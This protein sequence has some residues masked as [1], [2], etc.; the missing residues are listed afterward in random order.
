MH[1]DLAPA[2]RRG[3]D[4]RAALRD[5]ARIEGGLRSFLDAAG[6]QA[7]TDTFEDLDGLAQLPGIAAQRL[8]ADGYGFAAEGD[9]KTAA[10]V[11]IA[12]VM[13]SGLDGGTSFME[14]YTYDLA[15]EGQTRARG[16]HARGLPVDRGTAAVVR[17]PPALDRRQGRSG[18]PRLHGGAGAGGARGDCS[19]SAIASGSSSTRSSSCSPRRSCRACRWPARC[20]VPSRTSPTAAEAW[21]RAGGP[22]HTVLCRAIGAEAFVDLAEI[23]GIE[24]LVID[25]R[26]RIRDFANELRWNQAYYRLARGHVVRHAALRERVLEANLALGRAGLV[27]LTFGNASAID[28]DAGIVAIKPSGVSLDSLT[29]TDIAVVDLASGAVVEGELRPSSDTPTHLA[30]YRAWRDVGGIVHTHSP[31]ATAWAQARLDIPCYGTTHADH[32]DGAVPVTRPLSSGEIEGEYERATGDV[33]V[34]TLRDSRARPA[35]TAGGARCL[36]RPLH[37]GSDRGGGG[38]ER[39]RPRGSRGRRVPLGRPGRKARAD[40]AGAPSETLLAQAR[41]SGLLRPADVKALRLH[42]AGDLRLHEEPDPEPH[43]GQVLVR[44]GGV[45]LCGSDRHW[46]LEGGIGDAILDEPLVLGHELA[47]VVASGPRTGQRVVLDPAVPCGRCALCS[48]GDGHLCGELRFAGHGSTDGGLR[49]LVAWPEQLAHP[50]PDAVSDEA[51]PLLEPLGVALH[52]I[53]LGG[54]DDGDD[55]CR[56]RLRVDRAAPRAGAPGRRHLGRARG[57]SAARIVR[58]LRE[59]SARA[60]PSRR[61]FEVDVVYDAAGADGVL[62]A[63]IAAARPGGRVVVVGIPD[64]DRSTFHAAPAR[65]KELTLV[66]CRRMRASDLPRAIAL[67]E[68][69]R[70]ELESLVSARYSLDEGSQAFRDL[71]DRR[72]LKVL[73]EP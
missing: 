64:G 56:L 26:T 20:G 7:F 63:A 42:A 54:A 41:S 9:W 10:L 3:G 59:S 60:A 62:D 51:A 1:Y 38:R 55:G 11:R 17:D 61:A 31:F 25:E 40:R 66:L 69:G 44:V 72:G 71:V 8:M 15:P 22:H 57:R 23:A 46:F 39:D 43:A 32:F 16:A 24:L 48:A 53:D 5:A 21:L 18:A 45:G 70:L 29:V 19:T 52:A 47:G 34:E 49:T 35:G 2:L 68:S 73:V 50:L 13:S 58:R 4:R 28:R 27:V 65:R 33:I 30:L 37:L 6:F 12:K 36:A 14:D 67:A